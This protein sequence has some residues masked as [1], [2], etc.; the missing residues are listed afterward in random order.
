MVWIMFALLASLTLL[1]FLISISLLIGVSRLKKNAQKSD[2]VPYV[3]ILVPARDEEKLIAA[4]LESLVHQQYPPDKYEI[5]I[6]NDRSRDNTS[7]IVRE[8]QDRYSIIKC[9]NLDHNSSGLTGKQNA[10]NEGLKHCNGEIILNTDADCIVK[11]L[12]IRRTV[13]CF[14]PKVGL[15]IGLSTAYNVDG[16]SSLFTDLQSLD[17]L[18][19]MDA[20]AGSIGMN[21]HVGCA[22]SNLAYRKAILDGKGY[23]GI[24]YTITEDT[25]LIQSVARN[26]DWSITAVYDRD[27]AIETASEKSLKR[28]LAQRLRWLL[29]GQAGKDLSLIPLYFVFL[30]HSCIAVFIPLMFFI[31]SLIPFVLLSIL[32]KIIL[33]FIRCWRVCK[34]FDRRDL[35]YVFMPY[36]A[37]IIFYS[38]I[39]GLGS[40][41]V[42]KVRWKEDKYTARKEVRKRMKNEG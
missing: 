36:E 25:A 35:L 34:E 8:Y 27:A 24:G 17:T 33:D 20:A 41:F 9:I 32:I 4:C 29:G 23:L 18:F 28:F 10:M 30:F 13:S 26:T 6:V 11:P 1:Y 39:I 16:T 22:G 5:V 37:F 38:V 7:A 15:T 12:W 31:S 21:V 40:I 3:S 42:R 14:S 2:A 19:L